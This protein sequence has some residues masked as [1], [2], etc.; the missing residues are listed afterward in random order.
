[1]KMKNIVSIA[2]AVV[3]IATIALVNGCMY[4]KGISE[5]S[6]LYPP[7]MNSNPGE[8]W[9]DSELENNFIRYW[10]LRFGGAWEEAFG[11]EAPYF[12]KIIAP[13]RYRQYLIN[14]TKLELKEIRLME[15]SRSGK[16]LFLIDC[17]MEIRKLDGKINKTRFRD[18]W[19]L[20][21]GRWYHVVKDHIFFNE[22]S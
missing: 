16:T 4:L 6:V 21:D 3:L 2:M 13:L 12:Q 18:R 7:E 9:P 19:I 10:S 1:M 5:V 11:M 14:T 22:A 8:Y 17:E 15:M 20:V